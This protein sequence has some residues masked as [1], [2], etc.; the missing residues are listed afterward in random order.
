MISQQ[1]TLLPDTFIAPLLCRK[2]SEDRVY[3]HSLRSCEIHAVISTYL[4]TSWHENILD[5]VSQQVCDKVTH[6]HAESEPTQK[7]LTCN[8][9]T[10]YQVAVSRQQ[11]LIPCLVMSLCVV[12]HGQYCNTNA[13]A[14]ELCTSMFL[15]M[16]GMHVWLGDIASL[17]L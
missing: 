13:L 6:M 9:H 14:F 3:I 4:C 12:S 7:T 5:V 16:Y 10:F 2:L 17:N 8:L 11:Y 15:S 1:S